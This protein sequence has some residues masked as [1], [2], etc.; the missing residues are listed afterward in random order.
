MEMA[1]AEKDGAL[2]VGGPVEAAVVAG[3][4]EVAVAGVR[5]RAMVARAKAKAK[6]DGQVNTCHGIDSD[7]NLN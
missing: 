7:G 5:K 4:E 2:E 6:E 1:A 3:G